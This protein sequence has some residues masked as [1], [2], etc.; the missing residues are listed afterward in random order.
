[1]KK[2]KIK[3]LRKMLN[4]KSEKAT[5]GCGKSHEEIGQL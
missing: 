2:F 3:I 1:M 4:Q 5:G